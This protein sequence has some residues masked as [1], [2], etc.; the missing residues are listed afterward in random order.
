MERDRK[1]VRRLKVERRKRGNELNETGETEKARENTDRLGA[2][3]RDRKAKW[4]QADGRYGGA[5]HRKPRKSIGGETHNLR[6]KENTTPPS[7]IH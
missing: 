1:P 7:N 3:K 2:E 5:R 4:T 6:E